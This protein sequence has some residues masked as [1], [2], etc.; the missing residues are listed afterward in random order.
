MESFF[1]KT[2]VVYSFKQRI[3]AKLYSE[4]RFHRY[5]FTIAASPNVLGLVIA[6]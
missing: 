3:S 6:D 4:A 1:S 5:K 2:F